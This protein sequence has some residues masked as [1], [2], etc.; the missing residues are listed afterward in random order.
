MTSLSKFICEIFLDLSVCAVTLLNINFENKRLYIQ[1]S[2]LYTLA[3]E[4]HE[5]GVRSMVLVQG[6]TQQ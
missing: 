6:E 1:K 4:Q 2:N 5:G 3:A